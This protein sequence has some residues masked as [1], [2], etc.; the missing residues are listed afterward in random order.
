MADKEEEDGAV[1][2]SILTS[3]DANGAQNIAD[4]TE[5]VILDNNNK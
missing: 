3:G 1:D 2:P 4:D 5:E